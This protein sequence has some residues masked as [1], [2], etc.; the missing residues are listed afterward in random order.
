MARNCLILAKEVLDQMA[1]CIKS[2]VIVARRAP[3]GSRRDHRGLAR[4]R[5]RL[6]DARVGVERLVGDQRIG[7]HRG[8]EM[9][10]PLQVVCLATGQEAPERLPNPSTGRNL[11]APTKPRDRPIAGPH[12][13]YLGARALIDEGP[14]PTELQNHQASRHFLL[15]ATRVWFVMSGDL[16]VRGGWGGSR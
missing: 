3:V 6:K 1:R 11:G 13:L 7:L 12:Q 8:Q 2:S 9:V 4:G 14:S 16:T 5:Q 15:G 10:C